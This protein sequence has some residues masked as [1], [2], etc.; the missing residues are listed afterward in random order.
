MSIEK[1][2][3]FVTATVSLDSK[4]A[5]IKC[6][7][8]MV[9]WMQMAD[10][11][12]QRKNGTL[13]DM[14]AWAANVNA[15]IERRLME[16]GI[17]QHRPTQDESPAP[18]PQEPSLTFSDVLLALSMSRTRVLDSPRSWNLQSMADAKFALDVAE[19]YLASLLK[20][21]ESKND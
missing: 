11:L 12:Y 10:L 5:Q 2:R 9:H 8:T 20:T 15:A 4:W 21:K 1:P 14:Q 17:E 18:K 7:L 19:K 6:G 16:M 3:E 13:R